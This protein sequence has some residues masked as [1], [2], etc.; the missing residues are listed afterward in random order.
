[1]PGTYRGEVAVIGQRRLHIRGIGARPV[2][3]AGGEA[4]EGKAIWVIRDGDITIDNL[5]FR[6][7]R[8]PDFN[9]AGIRFE[10][11]RLK[12]LRCGFFDNENGL[13]SANFADAE[14]DIEDCEF[15]NAPP[16]RGRLHHLLY[17]GRIARLSIVGS[18]FHQ[19]FEGNLLESRAARTSISYNLIVDGAGGRASYEIDLPNGGI[20]AITGN[21]LGQSADTENYAVVA[22][23]AEGNAH[24]RNELTLSHNTMVSDRLAGARFLRIWTERLPPHTRVTA[25]NNLTIGPGIFTAG[26]EG[27]FAGNHSAS[28]RMLVDPAALDFG[29][30]PDAG[31]RG[32]GVDARD[33]D[34]RDLSPKA[35]F[36]LPVGTRPL[37]PPAR[38][39]PGAFQR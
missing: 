27:R 33:F 25:V 10:R 24:P 36:V 19:G 7:A 20:A 13:L 15:A 21:V 35:E 6:G 16:M 14:L 11:G 17:V 32:H 1:M 30:V 5:E 22:Y 8:V 37:A 2:F 31:P 12:L 3:V 34:G 26:I 29:L 18:R 28:R 23:G 38:W 9:G 4:A 39:S